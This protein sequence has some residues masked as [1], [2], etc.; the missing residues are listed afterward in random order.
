MSRLNLCNKQSNLYDY[1]RLISSLSGGNECTS[2][3]CFPI[4]IV[5]ANNNGHTEHS[6]MISS[7]FTQI[8]LYKSSQ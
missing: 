4:V 2:I 3:G 6:N 8:L 5:R 1:L 7:I